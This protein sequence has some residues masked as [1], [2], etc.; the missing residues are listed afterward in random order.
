MMLRRQYE[1]S[2][3][4]HYYIVSFDF[5]DKSGNETTGLLDLFVLR[6]MLLVLISPL[7]VVR[8]LP[9]LSCSRRSKPERN[10]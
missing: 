8:R 3:S 2:F 6:G 9:I 7:M 1:V 5:I 4:Y 10:D